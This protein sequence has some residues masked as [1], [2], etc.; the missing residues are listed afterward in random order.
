MIRVLGPSGEALAGDIKLSDKET[1]WHFTPTQPWRAGSY[2]LVVQNTIE[3]LAGN[4]IGKPFEVDLFDKVDRS[5]KNLA[6]TI[7]FRVR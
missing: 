6:T 5:I 1:E 4:N 3:D 7:P 2:R